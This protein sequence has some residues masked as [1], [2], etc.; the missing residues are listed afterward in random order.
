MPIRIVRPS[1]Q[2]FYD[3]QKCS[4]ALFGA[5]LLH[6]MSHIKKCGNMEDIRLSS[7]V[8][9]DCHWADFHETHVCS[10]NFCKQ[11]LLRI[12]CK[13]EKRFS[14]WYQ[15]TQRQQRCVWYL[16]DRATLIQKYKQPTR[17]INNNFIN[18]LNQLNMFRA[19]I[20]LILRSTRLCFERRQTE[21]GRNEERKKERKK[22]T[23]GN[24]RIVAVF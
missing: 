21:E 23:G 7:Y 16:C 9:R 18:N 4:T 20:S 15:V 17:C 14:P 12:S 3:T 8:R 22:E 2:W 11:L 1:P 24:R 10:T 6:G 13:T 5:D 19:I